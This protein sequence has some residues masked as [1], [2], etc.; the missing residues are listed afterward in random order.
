VKEQKT[1]NNVVSKVIENLEKES[2]ELID[3]DNLKIV[4]SDLQKTCEG[5]E[6]LSDEL[7]LI[8]SEYRNRIVGMMKAV[9]A[10]RRNESDTQMLTVLSGD[11][12]DISAGELVKL[13]GRAAVRFR[14]S[15]P[16]SFKYLTYPNQ[17]TV[18]KDWSEH[19]I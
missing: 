15:F 17:S 3:F 19:K 11:I 5:H 4:M 7:V 8:K 6:K 12:E 1:D 10:C 16:A 9:M 13:Y 18:Q 14:D 2:I